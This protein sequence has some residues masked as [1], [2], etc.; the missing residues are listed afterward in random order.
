MRRDPV[1]AALVEGWP[2]FL[3]YAII[4][5]PYGVLARQAG[6]SLAE[7]SATSFLIFAGSAQFAAIELLRSEAGTPVVVLTVLLVNARYLVMAAAL[8]P[9][10]TGS[11]VARRLGIAYLLT[12]ES[13]AMGIGWLRRGRREL[14]YYVTVGLGLWVAWNASTV[15]GAAL[16][17]EVADP[18]RVGVDFAITAAFLAIATLSVRHRTD[19]AV[20][21]VAGSL[22]TALR[23]A[24]VSVLAIV[25]AGVVAPLTVIALR[26]F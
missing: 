19:V 14:S 8:R 23:L 5:I 12:D 3:T 22:V 20:A 2:L 26:R 21:I 13:F 7:A 9:F 1:R 18:S 15:A 6:L 25:V 11:S 4:G 24:G 10:L 17:A 16:G